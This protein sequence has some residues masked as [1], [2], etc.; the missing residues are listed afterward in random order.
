MSYGEGAPG[1]RGTTGATQPEVVGGRFEIRGRLA[2]G[3]EA[4][5]LLARDLDLD[6]D[7]VLKTRSFRDSSDLDALRR[8]AALLMS[9]AAHR[10][11][12]VVRS[13]LV[14]GDRYYMI[15]AH[16]EG[17]D[18][19]EVVS[20]Q[21]GAMALSDVL[22]LID[23]IAETLEHLHQH[24]PVVVHGDLKPENVVVTPDG[25]AV[26]IDFG[27]A[28]R[29]GDER[30]RLGTPGFSAPEVLAG[31]PVSA[32][33]DLY[34]LAALAIYLLTGISPKLG[35]A[36]PAALADGKLAHLERVVRRG[37][38]WDPLGRPWSAVDFAR[39]LREAAEMEIPPGTITL[40]LV[41]PR[42]AWTTQ[43]AD[44][45]IIERAS[46]RP[47][48]TAQLPD[49][50]SLFVFS[51]VGDAASAAHALGA[52]GSLQIT[53]HAADL[54]GM[55]GA[56]LQHLVNETIRLS[57]ASGPVDIVCSSPVQM[58]LG[59][60]DS[61]SF[62]PLG[63]NR[64]ELRHAK[65][66]PIDAS[67]QVAPGEAELVASHAPAWIAAR[68]ST[69]LAG[70]EAA[71]RE[72][73][74][75]IDTSRAA[76]HAALVI[77][78]GEPGLGKTRFLSELAGRAVESGELV[79]VGRCSESGGA[80]EVFLDALGNDLFP[81]E[82]GQLERDEEG[83]I[84]RR[85][86]FGRIVAALRQTR[87]P[88]TLVLDDVQWIDGSSVALL[89][90]LLD[91]VGPSLAVLVACR[92]TIDQGLLDQLTSRPGATLIAM[93]P[94][95]R[96]GLAQLAGDLDVEVTDATL[97]A[98]HALTMG[99]PFFGLQLLHQLRSSPGVAL[100]GAEL[101][102]GVKEWILQQVERL[103]EDVAAT[104]TT[105][106]VMGRDFDV[107][108]LADLVDASAIETIGRLDLAVDSG[109][110]VEGSRAGE[111]RFV[112]AIVRSAIADSLS[113][114]RRGLMHASI[115]RRLE[116]NG[117]GL[118]DR[119][120]AVHHWFAADRL[121][122]PLHAG[123]IAADV[124][125]QATERLA[126]ER[127]ISIL[128]QALALIERSPA[129][130]ARDGV[131]AH[132]RVAHGRADFVATRNDDAIAQLY[133]AA[134]LAE[135]ADDPATLAQAALVA[136]LNRR[137]GLDDPELL[138]LLQRASDRCPPEPAVLA[139]M[140]HIRRSRLL[141]VAVPHHERSEM[142]R[143]GL[144]N[145]ASMDAVDQAMVETEVVRA[146]WSPDD[147]A[148]RDE[149]SSRIIERAEREVRS[150][151]PSRWTGVLIEALNIRWAA[152][153]QLGDLRGALAA[154][155]RAVEVADAAGTTFLLS[156]AMMGRAMIHATLGDHE[157]AEEQ[158]DAAIAMSGRHNL[159]LVRMTIA[160]TIGRD[161]GEQ[162]SLAMLE[163]QLA[164]LVDANPMFISAFALVHAEAGHLD[165]ARRLLRELEQLE[166]W[167]RNWTW[168][169][170]AVATLESAVLAGEDEVV[171]RFSTLLEPFEGQW[172]IA[173]A[174]AG[175]WGP[176]DRVLGL[177]SAAQGQPERAHRQLIRAR[178]SSIGNGATF[179]A[180][181]CHA[182]LAALA[183]GDEAS[184]TDETD[185][186]S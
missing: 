23:Q 53:L 126:H 40:M 91:D 58:L 104:L 142:A 177:A 57:D 146:C 25:R 183:G 108:T 175:C 51:R 52:S 186:S 35:S 73:L 1:Q 66:E 54:G 98:M 144:T 24:H 45:E 81:F 125:T 131:E 39:S 83:W 47:V 117:D 22:S 80:F 79:F 164:D 145:L 38:T 154:A 63:E 135:S 41:A 114:T 165:D 132:L 110:L 130:A 87:R 72:G 59:G 155:D 44:V 30:E 65:R 33:A 111:F 2:G 121:G 153:V 178:D 169:A 14:E 27:A 68:R 89:A 122:D 71:V 94:L 3:G 19:H 82:A 107:I 116:E 134:D 67:P 176:V 96:A 185:S 147:A 148:E 90:Q 106:A 5:V 69:P 105:A 173:A 18:L 100:D 136:S 4:S 139:A 75:A 101:P 77:V 37:L 123:E 56:T 181:R 6:V 95:S 61:Y 42:E 97:D 49:G 163:R 21:S 115:A 157:R 149:V 48:G 84:D 26:L 31:D 156:R 124:A 171:R 172:A 29:I 162:A 88:V 168:L 55:H 160:Y 141:P 70:R 133:R 158:S 140:L 9:V 10:G 60:D 85:R 127:A 137:H 12:P 74:V 167:P 138:R 78:S 112:H 103:G 93:E 62:H 170:T 15:S 16:I 11:L 64:I 143:L 13:D 150:G 50:N 76:A 17:R 20:A 184:G 180:A 182:G 152:R 8:E 32:S 86:F 119:E 7:V 129:S 174:E 151:G 120:A 34:S 36:W 46:G 113:A 179:W 99:S 161:R 102:A 28:M 159:T 43:Q 128:D 166:P 92:T 109:L 118:E